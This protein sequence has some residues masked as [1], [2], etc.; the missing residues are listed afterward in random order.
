MKKLIV[1]FAVAT[2]VCSCNLFTKPS[3]DD[4]MLV[5]TWEAASMVDGAADSLHLIYCFKADHTGYTYD[6]GD[7]SW[8]EFQAQEDQNGWFDWELK[9]TTLTTYDKFAIGEGVVPNDYAIS[10]LNDSQLVWKDKRN[11]TV[12]FTKR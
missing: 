9:E 12:S 4:G 7:T 6:E 11:R 5:G 8:E 3:Y 10:K 1:L 2:L